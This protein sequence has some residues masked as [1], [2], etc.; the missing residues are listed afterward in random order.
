MANPPEG[1]SDDFLEQ[2]LAIPPAYSSGG[3]AG[4]SEPPGM[5]VLQL[6]SGEGSGHVP[7]GGGF[8]TPMFPL[9]LSLEPDVVS[10]AGKRFRDESEAK[11]A[12][13]KLVCLSSTLP[14]ILTFL[15]RS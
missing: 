4:A 11:A 8:P 2:I 1:L 3:G 14:S 5:A 13:G 10:G 12:A 7:G 6:S 9:G 15:F